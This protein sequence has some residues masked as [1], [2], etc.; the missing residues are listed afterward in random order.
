MSKEQALIQAVNRYVTTMPVGLLL[1][2]VHR[3][4]MEHFMEH[5]NDDEVEAFLLDFGSDN[6]PNG[7]H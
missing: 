2:M 1:D 6:A 4:T 5:A 7:A 3:D